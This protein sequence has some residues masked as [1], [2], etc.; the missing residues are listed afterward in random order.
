LKKFDFSS[1]RKQPVDFRQIEMV[2]KKAE[3]SVAS[4]WN[5][6]K[7]DPES[8]FTLA[9]ESKLKASM[10]LMFSRGYRSQ[11]QLG[12][13]KDAGQFFQIRAGRK[14]RESECHV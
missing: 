4:S 13:H 11:V 8:A 5:I 7:K 3:K 1:V 2:L 12:H 14:L 9:Y 6:H 10:A